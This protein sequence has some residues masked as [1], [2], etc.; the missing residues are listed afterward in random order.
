[1][2]NL[3]MKRIAILAAILFTATLAAYAGSG[4]GP[5]GTTPTG[6]GPDAATTSVLMGAASVGLVGLRKYLKK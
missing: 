4:T 1:M 3:N 6:G 2:G 5:R